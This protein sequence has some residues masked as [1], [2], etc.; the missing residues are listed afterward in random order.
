[1]SGAGGTRLDMRMYAWPGLTRYLAALV[2]HVHQAD[3]PLRRIG[4]EG[5]NGELGVGGWV[6]LEDDV[7]VDK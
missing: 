3:R 2:G 4:V 5:C 7:G 6:R 1:M